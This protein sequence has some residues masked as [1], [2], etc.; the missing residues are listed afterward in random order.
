M[1]IWAEV[2]VET[3]QKM[4]ARKGQTSLDRCAESIIDW[5]QVGNGEAQPL[6]CSL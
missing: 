5:R 6:K 3:A 1:E 2:P 4:Q